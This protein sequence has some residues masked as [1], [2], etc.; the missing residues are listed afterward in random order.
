MKIEYIYHSFLLFRLSLFLFKN[1]FIF[2]KSN[3]NEI[4]NNNSFTPIR[5]DIVDRNGVIL[6]KKYYSLHAAINPSLIKDKKI[7]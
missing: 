6:S 4:V 1:N 2:Q 5:N 3:Y 7:Y